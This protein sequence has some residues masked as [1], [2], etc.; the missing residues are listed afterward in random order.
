VSSGPKGEKS[1]MSRREFLRQVA[2]GAVVASAMGSGIGGAAGGGRASSP[3][4]SVTPGTAV[5][6][7][8]GVK[9]VWDPSKAFT[10]S[11]PTRGRISVNGLWR[12]QPGSIKPRPSR[13]RGRGAEDREAV[14]AA[15]PAPAEV[16]KVPADG[17]GYYKVPG[18]WPGISDYMHKE[19]QTLY[20]HPDWKDANLSEVASAWYQ[21]EITIPKDWSGR[22]IALAAE[23]VNS[24]AAVYTDGKKVGE[25][26]F[27][28]GEA[29]LTAVCKP[30]RRYV[31][32]LLVVAMPLRGVM[33]SY[34]D[35]NSAKQVAGSVERRG[36]CGDVSLVGTP[37][38]ARLEHVR[39]DTSVRNQQLAVTAALADLDPK[40]KYMLR[41]RITDGE[42]VVRTAQS[43]PFAAADLK[44]GQFSFT[45]KWMPDKLW[46]IHTPGNVYQLSLTLL[47]ADKALDTALPVRFGYREFWIDG[48]D[49]YLNGMRLFIS[50]VPMDNAGV[51]AYM[52]SY[53]PA[54]ESLRRLKAIGINFVY[55]HNYGCE[56]GS[57]L[58]FEELLQAA[59]DV[60]MLVALSQPH[61]GQYRW[62]EEGADRNN[63]YARHAAY[64]VRVAGSHPSVVC[65]S[66]SHNGCGY[67]DDM[68]PD[69]ID[70]R[71]RPSNQWSDRNAARALRAQAII[72][73]LD[74]VRVVYHHSS[75][76][77]G[78]MHTSNFYPNWAPAQELSD[79]LEHWATTGVKPFF[80]VEYAAPMTWDWTMYRGWYK[81]ERTFGSAVVP[82]EFCQ[83]E[84][85][86]QLLGDRSYRITEPEKV[87]LRWEA[88]QF[89]DGKLWHRWDYPY[90]VG[91]KTFDDQH[92][93]CARYTADNWRAYRTWGMS[94]NSPWDS[95]FFWR[96][97][98]GVNRAR[99][100]LPVD[101]DHLQRP[102]LSAD[103][104]GDQY[105]RVD[106]AYGLSDWE[107]TPDAQALLRNNQPLLAYIAGRSASG[108][109]TSKDHNF[110]AGETVEKQI[111][112]INNSRAP[113]TCEWEWSANLPRPVRGRGA[114]SVPTGNQARV[115]IRF[116]LEGTPLGTY[117]IALTARFSNG[118]TQTDSFDLH[119]L[120]PFALAPRRRGVALFDPKGETAARLREEQVA[121]VPVEAGADLSG[122]DT[123]I[124]GKG[125]L[126]A[127]GPGPDLSRV[128]DG[129]KVIVFEQTA[130]ALEKRLGFRVTEYGLRQ[131]FPRV[132]DHPALAGLAAEHL[133]DWRGEATLTPPRLKLATDDDV[134]NGV[135]TVKWCDIPV[136]RVWRCGNRGNVA[137][138]LIEKPARG[139][140]LPLVDGGY[141]LQY[142]PLMEYRE[143][144]GM[145]LFCQL[146]VTGRSERDPAADGLVANLLRYAA[147]WQ[148][149]AVRSARYAG[150]AAGAKALQ[151]AG[152]VLDAYDGALAADE[153][154]VVAPGARA[155]LAGKKASVGSW[156]GSGGRLLALGLDQAEANSVLP[157]PVTMQNGEHVCAEFAPAG[158][159]S[160]L[161]GVGS[162]DTMNRDP[163]EMPLVSGGASV[164]GDG[165][166][167]TAQGGNAVLCQLVPWQFD[168]RRPPVS[169]E[170]PAL[171]NLKRTYR[172][173]SVLTARLL[174]NMG[175]TSETPVLARF[176]EPAKPDDRRWLDGLYLDQPEEWDDP[177]RFFRW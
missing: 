22:R 23:V 174:S 170:A 73:S 110:I 18:D 29:D 101:W 85:S 129:L 142:S 4:A 24:Y 165:V 86:A 139:N 135:G 145:I 48:K 50:S 137:S 133:R 92:E 20:P 144:K 67:S 41:A 130:E 115:P 49:F 10:E 160:P 167:A 36:L 26:L 176:R 17:W 37:K 66:T 127:D 42:R 113:V 93:I 54:K 45:D 12:W 103:Y 162:A 134:F 88:A 153:V 3:G 84:W 87:N 43:A 98:P 72:E 25:I 19:S 78:T 128:R 99:R 116:A 120:A 159:D 143:G 104:I 16:E 102:G 122:Y 33:L 81:G 95:A 27:P 69:M 61:F 131:V 146:D 75:G 156:L 173:V 21:R 28:A 77:L 2:A 74:P 141:G 65:Y 161:A 114:V 71:Q 119:V 136:T 58:A 44:N 125:A 147:A 60:G 177:Y 30:G 117:Q 51:S 59:D 164:V 83:A 64:Y 111:V 56:P 96:L 118:E 121:S 11:T 148:P 138:A 7:P 105:E 157:F 14:A 63:G 76:N 100:D 90:Q 39:V 107:A 80:T 124:I 38:A 55:G 151:A 15:P 79:W 171:M 158:M 91:N 13:R 68:N 152:F 31:L 89:R 52:S 8:R 123:L 40:T 166:L 132:P 126:T 34:S 35:T 163:R 47:A 57:H 149:A 168:W 169:D 32:S 154:L 1:G 53:A 172:R 112:V 70:G 109:F 9:A 155:Q 62:D 82:W 106:M 5:P 94:A 108:G 140:F 150:G 46:D 6:L 175:V 97:K